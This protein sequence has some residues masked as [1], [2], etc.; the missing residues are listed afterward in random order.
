[1][2]LRE[3]S[4]SF[5]AAKARPLLGTRVLNTRALDDGEE[6]SRVLRD[7]GAAVITMPA[8]RTGLPDDPAPL[9]AAIAAVAAGSAASPAFDW[10]AFTSAHAASAFLDRLLGRE[11]S[12]SPARTEHEGLGPPNQRD[13]RALAGIKLA[14]V[15]PATAA[16]LARYGLLADLVPDRAAGRH[17]A[18]ALGDLSR[19]RILLPRSDIALR[20]LPDALRARGASVTE[21]V[22]YATRPAP[23]DPLLLQSVLAG[24][25]DA[26]T[27]FSPSAIDG[28]AVQVAPRSLAGVLRGAASVCVG[29]TTAQ[30]ARSQGLA[31]ILVAEE[32]TAAGVVKALIRWRGKDAGAQREPPSTGP[33][34]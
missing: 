25:I 30:A 16:A 5:D 20:D 24:E 1:M 28:L 29:E 26:A 33:T 15:G 13:I 7:L 27:F 4:D 9:D 10:I 3:N 31:Q 2:S 21:V 23:A 6:L 32:A 17:L 22:A 34:L 18:A 19:L 14:A 8:I 11:E 12:G